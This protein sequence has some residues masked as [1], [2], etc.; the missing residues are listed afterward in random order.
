MHLCHVIESC[1]E[2]PDESHDESRDESHDESP[3]APAGLK[4]FRQEKRKENVQFKRSLSRLLISTQTKGCF[5][6]K[7]PDYQNNSTP[8]KG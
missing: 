5:L 7:G 8:T 1:D 3:D 6:L 2:S 4:S